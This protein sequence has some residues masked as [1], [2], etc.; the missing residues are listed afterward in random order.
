MYNSVYQILAFW[1][2]VGLY[3]ISFILFSMGITFKKDKYPLYGTWLCLFAFLAHTVAL[4]IRWLQVGHGP[5]IDFWEV[6]PADAWVG[7]LFYLIIQMYI[8]RIRILGVFVTPVAFL[9]IALAVLGHLEMRSIP[10]T[11]TTYWLYIHVLFAKLSYG[12]CLIAAAI[13]FIYLMKDKENIRKNGF[14]EKLPPLPNLDELS[15]RFAAFAFIMLGIMILSGSIWAN[16]SWGRYW[17]WDPIETWALVSWLI[18]GIYLHIRFTFRWKGRKAAWFTILA[19]L[20]VIFA[21][22]IS[23]FLYSSI[24]EHLK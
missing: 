9:M 6:I 18:Y 19:F 11:Y 3:V 8:P 17:G 24:H 7:V 16:L 14:L 23:P 21:Y 10:N 1:I 5:Y 12:S 2:A 15:Y 20:M 4:I 22:F 13:G